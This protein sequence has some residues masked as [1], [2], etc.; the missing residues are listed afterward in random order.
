MGAVY[1]ADHPV[2]GS[3]VAIKFLHPQ[4]A[5]DR[6][7]VERFY[8][9]ARAV[10]VIGH[11]N[12]LNILDLDVTEDNR[13]YFV[14]EFL[15]GKPLQD[16]VVPDVPMPLEVA[17]PI[18]LQICEALQA[19]HDHGIIHRDLKPDNVYLTVHKGKKNFVKVVDFGIA[20]VTDDSGASTGKTQT[21]MVMGTPAYMSPEQAGGMS[22]KIDGRSDVYSL[23]CMMFQMA[24][25]RLPF[26]GL[27][28]GEVLIGHLQ[29]PPP[30]PR[31]IVPAIPA[32]YE[33]LILRCLEKKQEA[34]FKGMHELHDAIARVVDQLGI[35]RELPAASAAEVAAASGGTRTKS[36]PGSVRTPARPALK[37]TVQRKTPARPRMTVATPAPPPHAKS[38]L[39]VWFA[40]GAA[41]VAVGFA[42]VI[43]MLQQAEENRR[44]AERAAQL[45]AQRGAEQARQAAARAEEEVR[46]KESDKV[47]LSVVSDPVGAIVEATWKDGVKA[48]VTPFD[49]TVPRNAAVRFVFSRKEYQ[50]YTADVVADAPKVVRAPLLAEPKPVA[51]SRLLKAKG[52]TAE[53]KTKQASQTK[54]DTIPVEF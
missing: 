52:G 36:S 20:R 45:A 25:G 33:A 17:G 38:R 1:M 19:A 54:D 10:D 3:R 41:A 49:L 9:E 7:I 26:P 48:A 47:Q 35:S 40:V 31:E 21:G 28:F 34:R 53:K 29:L 13:H 50:T 43:F 51:Q 15:Q 6:K 30:R 27:S 24:T 8:N 12:I 11:D 44:S 32:P 14:M 4:Y 23:G 39:G 22:A 37:S 46:Q 2:I 18:L 5:T 42:I 16:L